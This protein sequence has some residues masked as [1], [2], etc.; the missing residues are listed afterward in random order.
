MLLA[1]DLVYA[2]PGQQE[3]KAALNGASLRLLPGEIVCLVGPNGCGKS[4][5]ARNLNGLLLPRAGRVL[6]DGL[7]TAN[8]DERWQVRCRVGVVGPDPE[9]QLVATLVEEE[10]AFGPANLNLSPAEVKRRVE[11]ALRRTGSEALA[12]KAVPSLSAGEK[13]KVVL[14]A[15]LAME[16]RYL[17]LDEATVLLAPGARRAL[18]ELCRKLARE[19]G[20]GILIMTHTGEEFVLADRILVM[21]QGRICAALAPAEI[22]ARRDDFSRLGLAWP[23]EAEMVERLVRAGYPLPARPAT[24]EEVGE[25]LCSL[26]L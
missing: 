26:N 19:E 20:L 14:T 21:Q 6:V 22:L 3:A 15:V 10:I 4:T 11:V 5:L 8:P 12:G 17:I 13:Q 16:P 24:A 18:L 1:Q 25:I 9:S 7:D 23:P 2:F